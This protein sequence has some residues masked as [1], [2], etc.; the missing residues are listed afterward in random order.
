M[1]VRIR[2]GITFVAMTS[3]A[4]VL[5]AQP[6]GATATGSVARASASSGSA[7]SAVVYVVQGLPAETVSVAIDGTS[8]AAH[9]ATA[10]VVGPFQV[11]AGAH[12]VTF[13]DATGKVVATN[14]VSTAGGSNS[15]L[16]LHLQTAASK[17]PLVTQFANTITGIPADKA[18][19]TVA[20]T[21]AVPPADIRVDGKVLFANVA[22]GESLNVVVPAG[23]YRVDIVKAGE[24]A[25]AVFGPVDLTVKGG[26]LT[27]VYAVGD[28]A[29]KTMNV[30]VHEIAMPRSGSAAPKLIDTGTGGSAV[31]LQFF[32][33]LTLWWRG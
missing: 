6:A 14:T 31:F 24:Q 23:T 7:A 32:A 19:V 8:V 17:A 10:K 30:A 5:A 25:P 29:A 11:G 1:T 18:S 33:L 26:T 4:M 2:T 28:P 15:D 27:K 12:T 9:V 21:A 20:H 3:M 16:V 13:T 22:N